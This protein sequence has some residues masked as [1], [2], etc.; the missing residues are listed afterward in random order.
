MTSIKEDGAL[1]EYTSDSVQRRTDPRKMVEREEAEVTVVSC[2]TSCG[3]IL[4]SSRATKEYP[5]QDRA[6]LSIRTNSRGHICPR[7][8]VIIYIEQQIDTEMS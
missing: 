3:I 7:A 1:P 6:T 2:V 5:R 4:G 8:K